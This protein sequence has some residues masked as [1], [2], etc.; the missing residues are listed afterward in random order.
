MHEKAILEWKEEDRM[1]LETHN[2]QVMLDQI[3][4]KPYVTFVGVPGSGKTATARHIA[5]KLQKKGYEILPITDT[6]K[7]ED[8]CNFSSPQVFVIDDVL[9]VFGLK[10]FELD[11]INKYSKR[12]T[13][14]LNPKTK[15]L[16]T[17]RQAVFSHKKLSDSV[18]M[19]KENIVFLHSEENALTDEDKRNLLAQFNLGRNFL[20]SDQLASSSNMFPLLCKLYSSKKELQS[21]GAKFFRIPVFCI[22]KGMDSLK[23]HNEI[24]YAALVL[25]M[26]N[27]N[28][29]SKKILDNEDEETIEIR[30]NEESFEEMRRSIL[31]KCEKPAAHS[32]ELIN[33]LKEM[34]GTYT[35]KR[36]REFTFFHD[37][38]FEIIAYHFGCKNQELILKYARSN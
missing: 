15:I 38:L 8:Y 23:I 1:F 19:K 6:N 37:S 31:I 14:P 9:G 4:C 29:L 27:K 18:L 34:K 26:A 36:G 25:L 28:R 24:H 5:L 7:I 33:A 11:T 17:C 35:K 13:N 20:T 3:R 32:Y 10:Q 2:F 22:I 21:Y 12:L 16:M 30:K